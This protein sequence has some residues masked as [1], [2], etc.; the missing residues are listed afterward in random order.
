M[1]NERLTSDDS[2]SFHC[3]SFAFSSAKA[4]CYNSGMVDRPQQSGPVVTGAPSPLV[5]WGARRL[6]YNF[7][8]LLA[9]ILAFIGYVIICVTLLPRVL[10][11]S[12]IEVSAFTTLSQGIAYLL[13]MGAA[14]I[15]YFLGPLS[16]RIIR[17]ANVDRY[18][19]ICY[20]IGFWFSFLLPF[21]IPAT[22]GVLVL[23]YP[24]YWEH[25]AP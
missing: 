18:R 22:L 21:S 19:R 2:D 14:N 16:E 4:A 12:E 15:F 3:Q 8:L 6:H 24:E 13:A 17:P 11:T 23:F 20:R 5:W 1:E 25:N 10:D 9:G 7:G